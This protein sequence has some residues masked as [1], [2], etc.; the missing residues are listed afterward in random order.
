VALRTEVVL[1]SLFACL[2]GVAAGLVIGFQVGKGGQVEADEA[3]SRRGPAPAGA[4]GEE[5][6]AAPDDAARREMQLR[7]AI[8]SHEEALT[9]DPDNIQLL[10]TVAGFHVSLGQP[11]EALTY[12]ARA[13]AVMASGSVEVT[14]A[15]RENALV[16]EALAHAGVGEMRGALHRLEEAVVM[17]PS[18]TRSRMAQIWLYVMRI[19]PNPPPGFDRKEAAAR[20]EELIIEVLEIQPGHPQATQFQQLIDSV[21]SST[22][23]KPPPSQ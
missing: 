17:N 21:R 1:P 22:L 6:G 4:R 12:Y 20:A 3:R 15:E 23:S 16:D 11:E 5:Q 18:G 9:E 13:D 14:D 8:A 19:M 7:E 10:W 2:F